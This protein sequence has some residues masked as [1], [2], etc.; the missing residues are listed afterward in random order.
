MRQVCK[1]ASRNLTRNIRRTIITIFTIFVGVFVVNIIQAFLNGLHHGLIDNITQSRTGDI[2]VHHHEY[3]KTSEMLSLQYNIPYTDQIKQQITSVKD[4]KAVSP[5]LA[6]G[7]TLSTGERMAMFMGMGVIPED[8]QA[9]CPKLLENITDG[10]FLSQNAASEAVLAS[11]LADGIGA[12]VGDDLL[13]LAY[14]KDGAMNAVE[15]CVVGLLTDRLPLGNNKLV[16]IDLA[17]VQTLLQAPVDVTELAIA[18]SKT[19]KQ[20]LSPIANKVSAAINQG[21]N[22]YSVATWETLAK[23]FCDI[24]NIQLAVFWIIKVVLL[25]IVI[26]SIANT[27]LMS[28]FERVREIGTMMAIGLTRR[29]VQKLVFTE[30]IMLGLF[31]A[32]LGLAVS[33]LIILKLSISGFNYMAPGTTYMITIYP[34]ITTGDAIFAFG[35]ALICSLL[36]AIYPAIKASHLQPREAIRAV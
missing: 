19:R 34:F 24:M 2:Q 3:L 25:L 13:V 31:G 12:K 17:T 15:V 8:E 30:T 35:F 9:V 21:E 36:T 26:S 6:F 11:Q 5:R 23:V 14:T 4:V 32:V 7:G 1:V 33:K 20:N 28:V 29:G 22:K 16:F 27:M 18:T 10:R